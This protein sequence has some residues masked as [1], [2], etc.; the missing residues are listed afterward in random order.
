VAKNLILL[1]IALILLSITGCENSETHPVEENTS[2][3]VLLTPSYDSETSVEEALRSRRSVRTYS[4]APLSLSEVSQLLWAAQGITDPDGWRT[5]PSAG[6]LYP[7][8]MYLLAGNVTDLPVGVYHYHPQDHKL[9]LVREGDIRQQLFEA[10]LR[11]SA[12]KDGAIV[13]II[14]AEYERTTVK[15]G[16]RGIRYV[17]MEVGHVSQNVYLQAESLGLGTVFIGAFHDDEVRTL[18][19]LSEEEAPLGLMPVGKLPSSD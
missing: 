10:A 3:P 18:L 14:S 19:Q 12:V 2:A 8:E 9:T 6:A 17:H 7:L 16:E 4:S 13:L 1:V 15:Y 5:A 11:Q